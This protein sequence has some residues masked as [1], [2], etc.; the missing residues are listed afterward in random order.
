V[1]SQAQTDYRDYRSYYSYGCLATG[2]Y[3]LFSYDS[4]GD[5]WEGGRITLTQVVNATTGCVLL[6]GASPATF[7]LTTKFSVTVRVAMCWGPL[8]CACTAAGQLCFQG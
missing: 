7:N 1:A 8:S 3:A 5:G 4:Y 2:G 6:S